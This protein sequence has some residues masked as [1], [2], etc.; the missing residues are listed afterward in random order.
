MNARLLKTI[1]V[2]TFFIQMDLEAT[3]LYGYDAGADPIILETVNCTGS[4]SNAALCPT[5]PIG[6]ITNPVCRESNRAA[7]V[8]CT[9]KPGTCFEGAARLVDGPA[10]YE[11]RLEVCRNNQWLAVC[12]SG[13]SMSTALSVCNQRLFLYGSK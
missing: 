7:G 9:S 4:E 5:S 1:I 6:Q 11:G 10:F 8:R 3:P 2:K 13:F 12:E